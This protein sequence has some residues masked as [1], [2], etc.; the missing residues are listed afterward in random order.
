MHRVLQ[1]KDVLFGHRDYF[2]FTIFREGAGRRGVTGWDNVV[3][4]PE[5]PTAI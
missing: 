1:F 5:W 4:V 3:L 2:I